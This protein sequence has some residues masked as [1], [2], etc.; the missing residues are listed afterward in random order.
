MCGVCGIVNLDLQRPVL[1]SDIRGMTDSMV[2]RGPDD[3][4]LFLDANVGVGMR[5]LSIIDLEGGHQPM[6]NED[7]SVVVVFNG[8]IYNHDELGMKLRKSGHALKT[9]CDTEV[10]PHLY[11]EHGADMVH[12]LNGMFAFAVLDLTHQKLLLVRDHLGIKSLYYAR[13]ADRFI[14]S[15]EIKT[16]LEV[17][18]FQAHI[19]TEALHHYLTFRFVPAP[20]TMFEGVF[21]L[22]P[23]HLLEM[24][25]REA[26]LKIRQYWDLPVPSEPRSDS[27]SDSMSEELRELMEDAVRLRMIADVPLGLML[28]GGV[29]SSIILSCMTRSASGGVETFAVNYEEE[30]DHNEA[31][32]ARLAA[33]HFK[34]S[35]HDIILKETDF[36]DQLRQMVYFMDEP[37]AD[38]AAI[39]IF[40]LCRFSRERVKVL[41]SGLGGDELFAGYGLHRETVYARP[42]QML[43]SGLRSRVLSPAADR[44]IPSGLPGRNFL[45][46]ALGQ[47][48]DGYFG[49]SFVYGG[50]SEIQKKRLYS[51]DFAPRQREFNSH[52]VVRDTLRPVRHASPLSQLL[53]LDTKRWLADSHLIMLDKMSMANSIEARAPFMDHRLVEFAARLPDSAKISWRQS[54]IIL[55]DAFHRE[56]PAPI[57]LRPKRGFSTPL[58]IWMSQSSGKIDE[59]LLSRGSK[60]AEYF[61]PSSIRSFITEH[62]NGRQNHSP[63]LFMMLVLETWM[64]TYLK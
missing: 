56:I 36:F 26:D 3:D 21:K 2:H 44:F 52:R 5:R 4:G 39:P 22:S 42:I 12:R 30:G 6:T 7:G 64:R 14:F 45:T 51:E 55:K 37:I 29:D 15:S 61:E 18:G 35:H 46:R 59:L 40:D 28:S 50:L 32:F 19:D 49:S 47:I 25:I 31:P 16:F 48:E 20:L 33:N 38:P 24:D 34:A 53:Y 11:E 17:P 13:I 58:D 54:K 62:Q 41:L 8:E 10:L 9:S 63:T 43:P 1:G 23:G 27:A 60:S 57:R